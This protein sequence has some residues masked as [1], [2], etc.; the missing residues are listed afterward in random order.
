MNHIGDEAGVSQPRI[1]QVFDG[2]E[3]AYLAAHEIARDAI[4][5][6][7][8]DTA[9]DTFDPVG[10]GLRFR[11]LLATRPEVV[12]MVLHT[13]SAAYSVPAIAEAGQLAW[14]QLTAVLLE[15]CSATPE[16]ARDFLGRG[17][18]VMMLE[19][20]T[21]G[22]PVEGLDSLNALLGVLRSSPAPAA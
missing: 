4:A 10:T 11:E 1:S 15:E 20:M 12:M 22:R 5:Q 2:K 18:V 8:R 3:S 19:A 17:M 7:F 6:S 14:N 21:G 9:G 16:Q 13:G